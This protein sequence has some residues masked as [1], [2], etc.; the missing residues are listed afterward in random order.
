M[1]KIDGIEGDSV[2]V[3][4]ETFFW[5]MQIH[6]FDPHPVISTGKNFNDTFSVL[7]KIFNDSIW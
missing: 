5:M 4:K 7:M 2:D 6:P 3:K 1:I